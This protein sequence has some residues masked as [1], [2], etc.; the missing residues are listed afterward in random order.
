MQEQLEDHLAARAVLTETVQH[1]RNIIT[2]LMHEDARLKQSGAASVRSLASFA[3]SP[4]LVAQLATRLATV[5]GPPTPA[6]RA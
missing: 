5:M 3:P 1:Q 4:E 2:Q 6:L